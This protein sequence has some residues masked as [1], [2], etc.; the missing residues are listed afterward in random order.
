MRPEAMAWRSVHGRTPY[1]LA[2]A[3][4]QEPTSEYLPLPTKYATLALKGQYVHEYA[5]GTEH[6]I[7]LFAGFEQRWST[8]TKNT[9]AAAQRWRTGKNGRV[10]GPARPLGTLVQP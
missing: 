6:K 3:V 9:T 5:T 1:S 2:A 10:R 8:T 4:G 7:N